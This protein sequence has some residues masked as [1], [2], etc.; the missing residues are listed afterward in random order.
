MK[1]AL[2]C[3]A[4][5]LLLVAN[6]P[7]ADYDVVIR[8]GRVLDGAGN[9]WVRADVA[10]KGGRVVQVGQV[11]GHGAKEIDAKGRYVS[12]GFIDMMDQSGGVL[13][14]N[15]AAENKLRMGVTTVIAG[16]GGTPVE[17]AQIPSYFAQL[18]KQGISVNFGSYYSTTQ[19]RMKAMGDGA[20]NP[21]PAQMDIMRKEV[22]TAMEAGAFGVTSALIY[23]PSS[24]A[25]TA[26]LISMAKVSAQCGGFYATHMRDESGDL[27][28]AVNEAIEIGETSGAKVEIFHLKAAFAPG[29]GKLMPE[30]IAAVN[31]ARARG[32]DVAADLYPYTAGGTGLEIIA[33]SWVWADGVQKGIERLKDPKLRERMKKE[34][35]AG[36]MPGWSNLVQASGG[37]GNVILANGFSQKYAPYHGQSLEK[38]GAALK[39]DPADVAWDILLEGL[40]NRSVALYFMMNEGDIETALHQPWVSIGSDAAASEKFGEMDALGLP[41]PRAYGTFPRIIAEYVKRRPVL[42]LE[43]A[44]RKMTGWPAQRMGLTDRGLIRD[45]MRADIVIFDLERLDDVASWAKPTAAPTGIDTVLVNGVVTIED[46]K[47][48]GA[49]AGAVLRHGCG[50]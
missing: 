41:H 42:S 39:R 34:V 26:D 6:A 28:K 13:L 35:A 25:T 14:K 43:D 48:S 36:S 2:L 46:G 31:A 49:K 20:G 50:G 32:V 10:I 3:S 12:P 24:F 16:E 37:F 18:E 29:W 17:A 4:M 45:G 27:V 33:P 47:H 38:I 40:P 5:A 19:A 8:G 11:A 15:G 1:R 7:A 23:P 30:A 21:T 44:V 22:R 9:P